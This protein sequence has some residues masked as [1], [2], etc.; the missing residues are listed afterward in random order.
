M[1]F[2]LSMTQVLKNQKKILSVQVQD[3]IL[4]ICVFQLW[5]RKAE[6]IAMEIYLT[7]SICSG[8]Q[9]YLRKENIKLRKTDG[10][11]RVKYK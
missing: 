10:L 7:V 4:Y 9:N 1:T 6:L 11:I 8:R 3:M 2:T 5:L